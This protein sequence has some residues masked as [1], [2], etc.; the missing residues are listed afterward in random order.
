[1]QTD[2]ALTSATASKLATS[3]KPEHSNGSLNPIVDKAHKTVD[4]LAT[5]AHEATDQV[6]ARGEEWQALQDRWMGQVR[7]QV[8]Q[9][10]LT[11]VGVALALGFL[12]SRIM[13]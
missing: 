5:R 6:V 2:P 11:I 9:R 8:R 10:P 4:R 7:E 1:M 12:S 13:R 3:A